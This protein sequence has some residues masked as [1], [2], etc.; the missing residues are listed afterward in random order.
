MYAR[1]AMD[2]SE[3]AVVLTPLSDNTGNG[4]FEAMKQIILSQSG[5]MLKG[6]G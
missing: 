6:I 3:K 1:L 5:R 4:S 2:D